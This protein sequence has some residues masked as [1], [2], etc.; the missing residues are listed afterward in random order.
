MLSLVVM[1]VLIVVAGWLDSRLNW[2]Q[3]GQG[4]QE[5]KRP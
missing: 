1:V 3:A 2:Q 5:A 4:E